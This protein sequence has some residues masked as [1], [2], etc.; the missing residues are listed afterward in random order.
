MTPF[1]AALTGGG[2]GLA[3]AVL[4]HVF[5]AL[6][7]RAGSE[8]WLKGP[9]GPPFFNIA[10]YTGLFYAAIGAATGRRAKE[11]LIG[12]LGPFLTIAVPMTALTRFAR[13]GVYETAP[14]L[15]WKAVVSVVYLLAIWGTIAAIGASAAAKSRVLGAGAAVVASL[16]GYAILDL[17]I[18][19]APSYAKSPWNPA[20]LIPSP[21]NLMDGM[22]SG[23]A[24]TLAVVFVQRR[25]HAR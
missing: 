25:N 9:Y 22:L 11:A 16:L 21:I 10:V 14:S 1:A 8:A 15:E 5:T 3:G 13:L 6:F 2:A 4:A 7:D 24:L 20:G 19:L 17:F 23:A 18:R 12:L